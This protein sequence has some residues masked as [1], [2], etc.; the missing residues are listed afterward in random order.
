MLRS[1]A[2][3][4]YKAFFYSMAGLK[5]AW[6]NEA[7]FRSEVLASIVILPLGFYL[8]Q[9]GVERA[10]LM[11]SWLLVPI[12]ELLNCGLE[13]ITDYATEGEIHPLA[14]ATKD[15]GSAAVFVT[16]VTAAVIWTCIL[17]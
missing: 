3:R 10:L 5:T 17:F 16:M 12:V 14:K 2:I 13:T 8:G 1:E 7:P 15:I 9:N 6:Q 11:G 4:L